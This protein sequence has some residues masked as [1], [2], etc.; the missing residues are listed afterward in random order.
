MAHQKIQVRGYTANLFSFVLSVSYK[1]CST[2][3]ARQTPSTNS[4]SDRFLINSPA[5]SAA[6]NAHTQAVVF[7]V[8]KVPYARR[9]TSFILRWKP[10]VMQLFRVKW[11]ILATSSRELCNALPRARNARRA[12]F[13]VDQF[14]L[15]IHQDTFDRNRCFAPAHETNQLFHTKIRTVI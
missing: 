8:T 7:E 14:Y 10:S 11:N 12:F 4:L 3:K 6:Q 1:S 9:W 15:I 13:E 2:R 5:I